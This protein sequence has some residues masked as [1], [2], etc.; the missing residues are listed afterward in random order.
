MT[1]KIIS[2]Q[3]TTLLREHRS[4]FAKHSKVL[5]KEKAAV[6]YF[7]VQTGTWVFGNQHARLA[8]SVPSKE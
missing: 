2:H 4:I 8:Q 7:D 5:G 1:A 3:T 6:R